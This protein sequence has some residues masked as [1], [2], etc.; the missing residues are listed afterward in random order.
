MQEVVGGWGGGRGRGDVIEAA[1]QA[2]Q[3]VRYRILKQ[4]LNSSCPMAGFGAVSA[5]HTG[6]ST[7]LTEQW[8]RADLNTIRAAL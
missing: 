3:S 6:T 7:H 1:I 8:R 2:D 5:L 4:T